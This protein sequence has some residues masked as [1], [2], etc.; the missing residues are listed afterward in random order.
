M[1]V[2]RELN[3]DSCPDNGVHLSHLPLLEQ[4][5]ADLNQVLFCLTT[6]WRPRSWRL[7]AVSSSEQI[8]TKSE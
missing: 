3:P 1:G 2:V 5:R 7:V 4:P 8:R 6:T